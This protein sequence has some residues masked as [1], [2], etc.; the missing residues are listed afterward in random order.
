MSTSFLQHGR[1]ADFVV[2]EPMV[3]G[4]VSSVRVRCHVVREATTS[5]VQSGP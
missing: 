1:I 3:I 5:P 2:R 4:H